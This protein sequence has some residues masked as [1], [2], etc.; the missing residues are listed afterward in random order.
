VAS[1]LDHLTS[2]ESGRMIYGLSE[3]FPLSYP[4]S[5]VTKFCN[6]VLCIGRRQSVCP[7]LNYLTPQIS[8]E[9]SNQINAVIDGYIRQFKRAK[10]LETKVV[11]L[12]AFSFVLLHNGLQCKDKVLFQWRS[13]LTILRFQNCCPSYFLCLMSAV[14]VKRTTEI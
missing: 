11:I 1:S 5:L 13:L 14:P 6:L 12:K 4:E 10:E 3:S 2:K 9:S 8:F 7:G